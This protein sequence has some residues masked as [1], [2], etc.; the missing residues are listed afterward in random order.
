MN[1]P[2]TAPTMPRAMD[3]RQPRKP[4]G[5]GTRNRAIAPTMRPKTIQPKISMAA[6][7]QVRGRQLASQRHDFIPR[8]KTRNGGRGLEFRRHGLN[9]QRPRAKASG[10]SPLLGLDLKLVAGRA[11]WVRDPWQSPNPP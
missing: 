11:Q 5:P 3:G 7:S 4:L 10:P 6:L 9:C 8:M 2:T 1:P